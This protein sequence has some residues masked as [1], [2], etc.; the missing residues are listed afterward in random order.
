MYLRKTVSLALALIMAVS[1]FMPYFAEAAYADTVS[2]D[3]EEV[4]QPQVK[5]HFINVSKADATLIEC[6]GH[7]VLIDGGYVTQANKNAAD[8]TTTAPS[9]I[10][11]TKSDKESKGYKEKLYYRHNVYQDRVASYYETDTGDKSDAKYSYQNLINEAYSCIESFKA[12]KDESKSKTAYYTANQDL[13]DTVEA[14]GEEPKAYTYEQ[15][16]ARFDEWL[17]L[18]NAGGYPDRTTKRYVNSIGFNYIYALINRYFNTDDYAK[19]Y[20][21][22]VRYLKKKKITH[23]DYV[24][25]THG[26]LD[27]AGGLAAVMSRDDIKV[28]NVIYNGATYSA[29]TYRVFERAMFQSGS[30]VIL[31][32]DEGSNSKFKLGPMK[33]TNLTDTSKI[34]GTF[35]AVPSDAD[36]FKVNEIVN[37]QTLVY[38]L[39]VNGYSALFM[40]DA[41]YK[42]QKQIRDDHPELVDVDIYKASHHG[43]NN[44]GY[45]RKYNKWKGHSANWPF[46]KKA[47]PLYSF[48]SCGTNSSEPYAAAMADLAGSNVY[49]TNSK[50]RNIKHD[51]ALVCVL[52]ENKIA[53]KSGG[54]NAYKYTSTGKYAYS[55]KSNVGSPNLAKAKKG[56]VYSLRKPESKTRRFNK[57]TKKTVFVRTVPGKYYP[58]VRY[59]LSKNGKYDDNNWIDGKKVKIDGTFKGF[60]FF[61]YSNIFGQRLVRRTDGYN[62]S[63]G[64]KLKVKLGKMVKPRVFKKS[65]DKITVKWKKSKDT[66]GYQIKIKKDGETLKTVSAGKSLDKKVVKVPA[67]STVKVSVRRCVK[68]GGKKVWSPWSKTR[69]CSM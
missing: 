65:L 53:V 43:H 38:R 63:K 62:V 18:V 26:H 39:D 10:D 36:F 5:I 64:K 20:G 67:G 33:F 60:V 14:F 34:A 32:D 66:K 9:P 17:A 46:V 35:T 27:H 25:S 2:A 52:G 69:A 16:I 59:Q 48:I 54:K 40:G 30:N 44:Y 37:D 31:A 55:T 28:D 57:K 12:L 51:P 42:R 47:T 29:A 13:L 8:K 15:M 68:S 45:Q 50:A 61:E 24:I 56:F 1:V 49:V 3:G 22:T 58:N 7:Y 4:K 19:T 21:D 23:L 6:D 41:Q 11:G